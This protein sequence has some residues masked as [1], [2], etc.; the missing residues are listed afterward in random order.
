MYRITLF[1]L[2]SCLLAHQAQSQ[3]LT[4]LHT[5][6]MHSRLMGFGP[7][8]DYTP[9]SVNDDKTVGGFSRIAGLLGD[10]RTKMGESL[11]VLDAGDFLMGTIFHTMEQKTGF[12]LRLMKKMGYDVVSIGNHEFD[13]GIGI[14][15][16]ILSKSAEGEIPGLVLSNISF[17]PDKPGDDSM[18]ALYNSGVISQYRIIT[19][20]G[21]KIGLFALMGDMA[22]LVAP[23]VA[24]A[25]F[26]NR[27]E[28]ARSM[29]KKLKDDEKVDLVICLSHSG[30]NFD[31]KKGWT[32]EDIELA[33]E[34][35]GIDIIISGHTH[36]RLSK[37]LVVNNVPIVQAGS[38]GQFVGKLELEKTA[39]GLVVTSGEL[40]PVDDRIAGDPDIQRMIIEEQDLTCNELFGPY[41]YK[42]DK[43]VLETSFD[44]LFNEHD[45]LET[46]NLG[47]FLAD[48]MYY[49]AKKTDPDP[50]HLVLVTAG[51]TRDEILTGKTGMQLPQDLF[52]I[53]PLGMG[54]NE[55]SPG[56]SMSKIYIT[57]RELKNVLEIMLLAP[58][59][60]GGNYPFWSGVRFKYNKTRIPLDRIYEVEIGNDQD[61]YQ[62]VPLT[63]DDSR[64]YSLVTNAYVLEFFGLVKKMTKGILKVVPKYADG[65]V[66]PD[67]KL[68]LID[69]DR[70]MPGIQETKEWAGLLAFV[71][72]LPDTNGNGIPDVPDKYSEVRPY[73]EK[74]SSIGLVKYFKGTNGITLVPCILTAGIA[75][76]VLVLVL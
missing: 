66:I 24:P 61:G 49:Y 3:K 34:A 33:K 63:K 6:D 19:R 41:G 4:I 75:A 50:T 51:L 39:G 18:E 16:R 38:E 40:I 72:Q 67:F 26:T 56:Y 31:P 43:P 36:T 21:L 5:N 1:L 62:P 69:R 14:L 48:A 23:F 54:V 29:V 64:L 9:L 58:S 10:Y 70:T 25:N 74:C 13:F 45:N 53:L 59:I 27:I 32:G 57:G 68:A 7:E 28:I 46:S 65:T 71:S 11:L 47:S 2:M 30:I 12:Q 35:R 44:L 42:T 52:R 17:N 37:P 15:A 55:E 20:N 22:A 60:S 73:S 76:A 8:S